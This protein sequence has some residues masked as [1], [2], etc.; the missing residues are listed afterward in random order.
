MQQAAQIELSTPI[1]VTGEHMTLQVQVINTG[2]G[3]DLP[4]GATEL[5][6]VWLAVEVIDA[7]GRQLLSTG[8]VDEYGDPV[9]SSITYGTR[10]LDAE[11]RPTERLWEAAKVLSDHRIPPGATALETF[12]VL[13]PSDAVG[14]LHIHAALKYR[15]TSGYLSSLMAIYLQ[16]EV[17]AAPTIDL[18]TAEA[19]V[20]VYNGPRNLDNETVSS[21]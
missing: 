9:E 21:Q 19:T 12:Q 1:S 17:P 15:A 10:W 2:A 11:G 18:A 7:T 20:T 13:I 5:R 4:T 6:Q 14:P 8:V 16:E 3:H